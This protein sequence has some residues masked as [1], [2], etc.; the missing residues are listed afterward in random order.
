M[1]QTRSLLELFILQGVVHQPT[2]AVYFNKRKSTEIPFFGKVMTEG[3][4]HLLL[5]FL[6][7]SD[8]DQMDPNSKEKKL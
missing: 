4:F 6:H 5:N 8:N 2:N 1:T 3:R 7:F